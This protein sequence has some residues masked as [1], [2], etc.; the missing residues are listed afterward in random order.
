MGENGRKGL[1][2]PQQREKH[3]NIFGHLSG[4]SLWSCKVIFA[5][6]RNKV[7]RISLDL[8]VLSSVY[9]LFHLPVYL[10]EKRERK[11]GGYSTSQKSSILTSCICVLCPTVIFPGSCSQLC[12]LPFYLC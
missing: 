6:V 7:R 5:S 4:Q 11:I 9:I 10:M 12:L 1:E 3:C 8:N 2:F